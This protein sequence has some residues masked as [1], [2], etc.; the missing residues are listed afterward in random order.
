MFILCRRKGEVVA[1]EL[2]L[3]SLGEFRDFLASHPTAMDP[4]HIQSVAE[5]IRTRGTVQTRRL[6]TLPVVVIGDN[7]REGVLAMGIPGR[8][9]AMLDMVDAHTK[10]DPDARL[11]CLEGVT[12][13]ARTLC[14]AYP[15]AVCSEYAPDEE[16]QRR[17]APVPHVDVMSMQFGDR[18]FDAIVSGDVFEHVPDLP[19]ALRECARVLDPGGILIATFPFAAGSETTIQKAVLEEGRIRHLTEPEY[20]GDPMRPGEGVLV[21]QIPGWDILDQCCSAGFSKAEMVY[22]AD[23]SRGIM[24]THLEGVL[25]L[26]ATR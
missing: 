1:L 24:A 18:S 13:F 23:E 26:R 2:R 9:F 19:R 15:R 5:R 3:G 20:H 21:F 4:A 6:G 17:I 10:E 11:L 8:A 12:P 14:A 16:S 25:V 7:Y 22:V